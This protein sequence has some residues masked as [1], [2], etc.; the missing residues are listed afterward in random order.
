[1]ELNCRKL[2]LRNIVMPLFLFLL[3]TVPFRDAEPTYSY[4]EELAP[5][6]ASYSE[7]TGV[8]YGK[9]GISFIDEKELDQE[10]EQVLGFAYAN[11]LTCYL[12]KQRWNEITDIE[13]EFLVYHELEHLRG[14]GHNDKTL[15]DGCP[16]DIMSTNSSPECYE[17]HY[18][19][20]LK[21]L[22]Q[23]RK[24]RNN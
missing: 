8:R 4:T 12:V 18:V 21:K 13:K 20:Y 3:A 2:R 19:Y 16:Y 7:Y 15:K 5:Y 24:K 14:V 6:M 9:Y 10:D 22:M 11:D 23:T 17:K 1:M